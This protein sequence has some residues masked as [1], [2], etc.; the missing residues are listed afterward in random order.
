[1]I[2]NN[3]NN[4]WH[5]LAEGTGSWQPLMQQQYIHITTHST[6]RWNVK[7]IYPIQSFCKIHN[8]LMTNVNSDVL[9]VQRILSSS[10][11][12]TRR[13]PMY[14]PIRRSL[15][16][17]LEPDNTYWTAS[18]YPGTVSRTYER[19]KYLYRKMGLCDSR[20]ST[21]SWFLSLLNTKSP[22][23]NKRKSYPFCAS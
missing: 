3:F 4:W 8:V 6:I 13:W 10:G 22:L 7:S 20:L 15:P 9:A 12:A 2:I 18:T 1:M 17:R 11:L 19:Q 16:A 5:I 23:W 14:F 21:S